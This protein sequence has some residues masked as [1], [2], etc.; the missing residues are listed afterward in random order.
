[1]GWWKRDDVR[2]VEVVTGCFLFVR[3]E[4][5]EDVGLMDEGFFMYAEETDWCYRFRKHGWK[6]V[7]T[8][9]AEIV[10]LG[11]QS[12]AR[13]SAEMIVQLRRSILRFIRKNHGRFAW[14]LAYLSTILFLSL[15]IPIWGGISLL[16]P[17]RREQG[18]FRVRT[19]AEAIRKVG[20][21]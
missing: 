12:T 14:S 16:F 10:H 7:F 13:C 4:A 20:T 11:G 15:R 17:T 8:P 18:L 9:S 5:F 1:M 6:V 3:R 2:E 19:Y 21:R